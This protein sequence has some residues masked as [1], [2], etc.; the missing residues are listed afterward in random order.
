MIH[1][2][3]YKSKLGFHCVHPLGNS[4][5]WH[6]IFKCLIPF[7]RSLYIHQ[8]QCFSWTE[9]QRKLTPQSHHLTSEKAFSRV[10][11]LWEEKV[12]SLWAEVYQE[13]PGNGIEL[14][15]LQDLAQSLANYRPCTN[16]WA[17]SLQCLYEMRLL[18][19]LQIVRGYAWHKLGMQKISYVFLNC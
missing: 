5:A 17:P 7:R 16:Y 10:F 12:Q 8:L 18:K 19:E 3:Q 14:A 9:S 11:A 1:W 2:E 13:R 4:A 6:I 15:Q